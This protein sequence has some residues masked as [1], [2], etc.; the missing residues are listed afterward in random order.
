MPRKK[1]GD[2]R[3][4]RTKKLT[5]LSDSALHLASFGVELKM[6]RSLFKETEPFVNRAKDCGHKVKI[7]ADWV[8]IVGVAPKVSLDICE[9]V[10]I[11]AYID[12]IENEQ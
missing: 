6:P 1:V 5:P 7:T 3:K 11:D 10:D 9:V 12:E 2:I 8:Q 4:K